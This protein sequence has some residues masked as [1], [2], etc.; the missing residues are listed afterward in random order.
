MAVVSSR[1]NLTVL[2]VDDDP[3]VRDVLELMFDLEQY[4]V[5]GVASSGAQAVAIARE[6]RPDLVV[7]DFKMPG[8]DG[9]RAAAAIRRAAPGTRIV[10]FSA[11]LD[12][13]PEWA[14]G[15]ITKPR[16]GQLPEMLSS[17]F[18]AS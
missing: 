7:L 1:A 14:D 15:H 2:V 18:R 10:A 13:P 11:F 16:I 8:M 9:R 4:D 17:M 12:E 6:R 5:V 3:D